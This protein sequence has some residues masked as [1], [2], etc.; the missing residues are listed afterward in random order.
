MN[1][2]TSRSEGSTSVNILRLAPRPRMMPVISRSQM[3][4]GYVCVDL[5]GRDIAVSEQ[6]LNRTRVS[7]VLQQVRREAV[8]Q[9]VR[10]NVFDARFF[11]VLLDHGPGDLSCERPAAMQK[12]KR[13]SRFAVSGFD[14]RILLQPMNRT[15]AER[16]TALLVPFAVT[17]DETCEEI[18]VYLLQ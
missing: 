7:A 9:G 3:Q 11:R 6:R 17:D 1:W 14:C 2:I 8:S 18:D 5:R 15:L 12:N 13:R 10:R 4:I 16:H